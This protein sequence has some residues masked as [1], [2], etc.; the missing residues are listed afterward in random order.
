MLALSMQG[1]LGHGSCVDVSAGK[2]A[3]IELLGMAKI[4]REKGG[5]LTLRD[6]VRLSDIER[7][8]IAASGGPAVT[9]VF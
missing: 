9:M 3:H 7:L 2:F 6:A 4:A 5:H 8:G 1:I